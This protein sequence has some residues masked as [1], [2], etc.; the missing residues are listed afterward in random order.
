MEKQITNQWTMA[1]AAEFSAFFLFDAG[2]P[3]LQ[4]CDCGIPSAMA[5]TEDSFL[6][7]AV[8]VRRPTAYG[9]I[10]RRTSAYVDERRRACQ[11]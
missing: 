8:G 2:S 1:L 3:L 4:H 6:I 7:R 11:R 9:D 5:T 10:R